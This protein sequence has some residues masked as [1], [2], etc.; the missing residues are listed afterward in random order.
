MIS[1]KFRRLVNLVVRVVLARE[2]RCRFVVGLVCMLLRRLFLLVLG[3]SRCFVVGFVIEL[4]EVFLCR[5]QLCLYVV[6]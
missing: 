1:W 6:L 2:V 3:T 4:S 5:L